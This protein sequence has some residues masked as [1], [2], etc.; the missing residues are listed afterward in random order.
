MRS[1]TRG[2]ALWLG[3]TAFSC[4]PVNKEQ[5]T[6]EVLKADPEFSSVLEKRRE[7]ANRIETDVRVFAL[8]RADIDR[9]IQQL[10]KELTAADAETRQK[11]EHIKSQME[12]DRTRLTEALTR[13]SAELRAKQVERSNTGKLMAEL[14][15]GMQQTDAALSAQERSA[16][17]R[18]IKELLRNAARLDQETA[19]LKAHV[20]L[21]KIKLTLIKL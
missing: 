13:A 8:K 2:L 21:L 11:R 12:P 1:L 5:L 10:R 18:E 19:A 15:K 6:K 7:L 20:R 9:K 17:E 4:T 3:L 14:K 16:K